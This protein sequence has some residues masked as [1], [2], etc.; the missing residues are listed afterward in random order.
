MTHFLYPSQYRRKPS[1]PQ[2]PE[3]ISYQRKKEFDEAAVQ[4]IV[5][6]SHAFNLFRNTGMKKFLSVAVPGYRGPHRRTVVKRL[7]TVYKKHRSTTRLNLSV[8]SDI[9]L[10]ADIWKNMRRD[11]FLC[12]SAH[13]YDEHYNLQ[14]SVVASGRFLGNHYSER[15][16]NFI[17]NEIE[18]LGIQ[19]KIRSLTT[20]NGSD[21]RSA[22][23]NKSH[24][25]IR[26]SCVLHNLNLI[27]QNGLWLFTLPKKK[28]YVVSREKS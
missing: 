22:V 9:S 26:I 2:V 27:V 12:L 11:H 20:D 13:Y 23:K 3:K 5:Q 16:E 24:F 8:I 1:Q 17:T 15:I 21:I 28:R 4:A 10:S 25:G 7:E 6:D 19:T 18:K 14:S